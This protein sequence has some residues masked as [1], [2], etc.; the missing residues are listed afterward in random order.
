VGFDVVRERRSNIF[1]RKCGRCVKRKLISMISNPTSARI[2]YLDPL[3]MEYRELL[4]LR[5]R[6]REVE[7]AAALT[8]I[9]RPLLAEDWMRLAEED[10][11]QTSR[12]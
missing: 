9:R 10:L 12:R 5:E 1:R 7:A 2:I 11:I 3:E 4:Q 6:V 8:T